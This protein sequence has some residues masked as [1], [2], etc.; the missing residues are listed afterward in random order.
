MQSLM[1]GTVRPTKSPSPISPSPSVYNPRI[2]KLVRTIR[3]VDRV[4][5]IY[6]ET[7]HS[8]ASI[9]QFIDLEIVATPFCA[10][11]CSP[12]ASYQANGSGAR[13]TSRQAACV[14]VAPG[15]W[16]SARNRYTPGVSPRVAKA[17]SRGSTTF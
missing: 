5:P 17:P 11:A 10:L 13:T 14:P 15:P 16:V 3:Q 2:G 8:Y 12:W 6:I 7:P 1:V 9:S 4:H